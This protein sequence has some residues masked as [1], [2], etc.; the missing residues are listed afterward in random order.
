MWI[1]FARSLRPDVPYWPGRRFLAALDALLW[2]GLWFA[3][4]LYGPF[5]MGSVGFVAG[6]G[7]AV[8]AVSRLRCALCRNERYRFTTWRWG[9][10]VGVA[11]AIGVFAKLMV[12]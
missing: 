5:E 8:S 3:V 10:W 11:A 6:V 1:L 4:I 12:S 2:P 7:L 9:V